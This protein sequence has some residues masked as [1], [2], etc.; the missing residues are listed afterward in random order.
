[1]T[2]EELH[3]KLTHRQQQALQEAMER[4][5]SYVKTVIYNVLRSQGTREDLEELSSDV[6]YSLWEHAGTISRGKIKAWL[7][8]VARNRAKSFLRSSHQTLPMDEDVLEL[9]DASPENQALE[10]D[11]RRRLLAA[12]K[13]MPPVDKEIFLRYYYEYQTMERI[14]ASMDIP[15]GT[16]KSRLSRGRRRL[17][18]VIMEQEAE[19]RRSELPI[20][21]TSI[22]TMICPW[23]RCRISCPVIARK[24][25]L[26]RRRIGCPIESARGRLWRRC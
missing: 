4:Y 11:V 5:G 3:H 1:M 2:E 7:G 18:Q 10:K 20:C 6:F 9:P 22:W 8:A 23:M 12:V 24:Q 21:W 16:I 17:K 14:S 26:L 19:R 13:S 25:S 15:V